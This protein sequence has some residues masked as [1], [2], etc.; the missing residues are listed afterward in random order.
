MG[1]VLVVKNKIEGIQLLKENHED[2]R[3]FIQTEGFRSF[4][5][6]NY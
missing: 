4:C 3:K 5:V 2:R 1:V 6:Q